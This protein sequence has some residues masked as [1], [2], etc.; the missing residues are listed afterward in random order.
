MFRIES[1]SRMWIEVVCGLLPVYS[2]ADKQRRRKRTSSVGARHVLD[3]GRF[4]GWIE[5]KRNNVRDKTCRE[6]KY[7]VWTNEDVV[8]DKRW[9]GWLASCNSRNSLAEFNL[10]G[11]AELLYFASL[12]RLL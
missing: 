9:L 4:F 6:S 7:R 10:G 1:S 12:D 2:Q 8:V 5:R 11:A 3:L